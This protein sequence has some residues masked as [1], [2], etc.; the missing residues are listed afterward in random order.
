MIKQTQTKLFDFSDVG[1]DFCSGS[2]NKFPEVFKKMLNTGYN[3]QTVASSSI[4]G[5]LVTLTFG[6][7]HGYAADRVLLVTATG[8]FSKEV[9]I[10]SVTSNTIT[11]TQAVTTGLSGTITTKVASLGWELVYELNHIHIYKFKHIDDTDM[12]ARLC[13]QNAT[14]TGNR[15][16]IAVG[17]GRTANLSTG[18]ITDSNC[19]SDLASCATVADASSNLRWDF[20]SSTARTFDNYNYSQGYSTFGKGVVVGSPYHLFLMFSIS[21]T[22]GMHVAGILPT[23]TISYSELKYPLLICANNGA[24][25]TGASYQ[26]NNLRFYVGT[27][28]MKDVDDKGTSSTIGNSERATS[29]YIPFDSFNTSCARPI[30][31]YLYD[32]HIPVGNAVGG[33]Y[34]LYLDSSNH[35]ATGNTNLPMITYDVDFNSLTILSAS[36]VTTANTEIWFAVPIEEIKI[37]S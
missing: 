35:P 36:N 23:H 26:G 33:A 8:G 10:D 32:Q 4:S 22:H 27:Y 17:I 31:L 11:F 21:S 3:P 1:L 16:C 6:V 13:F 14:T 24:S 12:F 15:N 20:T 37:A 34:I 9:Y 25:T 19:F 18:V 28:R 29:S 5:S 7:N 30:Q 2:K